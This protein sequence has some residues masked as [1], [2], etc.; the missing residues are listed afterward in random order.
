MVHAGSLESTKE[1][2]EL[3]E[4]IAESNSYPQTKL[5]TAEK[6]HKSLEFTGVLKRTA[7]YMHV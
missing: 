1:A 5:K 7:L 3:L 6:V 2:L 4:A